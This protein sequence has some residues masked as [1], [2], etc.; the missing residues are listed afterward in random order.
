LFGAIFH[1]RIV[2]GGFL[3][4]RQTGQSFKQINGL[5]LQNVPPATYRK[6]LNSKKNFAA[7]A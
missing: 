4:N 1:G 2:I 5:I 7:F 6:S 3:W